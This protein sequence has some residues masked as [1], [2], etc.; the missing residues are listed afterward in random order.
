MK[1]KDSAIQEKEMRMRVA[2]AC[3]SC[4]SKYCVGCKI[5]IRQENQRIIVNGQTRKVE[6][7]E[8]IP[9]FV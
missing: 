2:M 7:I 1:I 3:E 5:T 9:S 4:S 6:K 8:Q